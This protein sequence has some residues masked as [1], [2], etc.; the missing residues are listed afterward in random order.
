MTDWLSQNDSYLMEEIIHKMVLFNNNSCVPI[1]IFPTLKWKNMKCK[2]LVLKVFTEA[3]TVNWKTRAAGYLHDL[4]SLK[5][6]KC[7]KPATHQGHDI[8]QATHSQG[9]RTQPIS[10][11]KEPRQ[12]ESTARSPRT[13]RQRIDHSFSLSTSMWHRAGLSS[14]SESAY[15]AH[16]L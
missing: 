11:E 4:S 15:T 1:I 6:P 8:H 7:K 13:E 14:T 3:P 5:A 10:Q 2:I 16:C 12:G 9:R